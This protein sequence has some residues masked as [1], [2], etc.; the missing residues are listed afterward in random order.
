MSIVKVKNITK[1][2]SKIK[3]LDNIS[4]EIEEGEILGL[5][6]PSGSG[7]ST[8]IKSI[9]GMEKISHGEV[10]ILGKKI[11]NR[12]ILQDI[13]YMAQSDALYEDLTGKENLEFFA[14]I[15]SINKYEVIKRIEYV[16]DLVNMQSDLNKKVKYYS[17]GMKRRLSLAI[18]LIQDPKVLI[19]DE[20]TVGIDPKLRLSIWNEL[21]K[22]KLKG[23]SI[24]ITTHVMDEAQRCDK[25]AL[26]RKGKIIA[27]GTPN[28][29]KDEFKV[30][31][32][33]DIFLK[34]GGEI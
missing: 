10:L 29:L 20:P 26:I 21:N 32:I 18:S 13:G 3:I 7:K 12:N 9:I 1:E 2:I 25:L 4:L 8:F 6:G 31:T 22:L 11:P 17:G 23:K 28:K 5:I 16:S 27:K 19:L 14:K 34:I 15:F 24:I 33:E 30:E